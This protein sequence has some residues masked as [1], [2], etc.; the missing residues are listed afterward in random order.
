[1]EAVPS[2]LGLIVAIALAVW[3]I[4]WLR[5]RY[6]GHEDPAAIDYQMLTQLGD[7]HREGA[8]SEEEYRSIKGRL[9]KRI[10]DST[11]SIQKGDQ[12]PGRQ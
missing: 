12:V 11:R 8:L 3:L 9:I 2:L 7:L 5:A 4:L 6:R 10:D 1:L